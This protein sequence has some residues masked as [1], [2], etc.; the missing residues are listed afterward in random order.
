M[1]ACEMLRGFLISLQALGVMEGEAGNVDKA[2][3]FFE[4]STKEDPSHVHSWQV[5]LSRCVRHW[6][7]GERRQTCCHAQ[8]LC[9]LRQDAYDDLYVMCIYPAYCLVL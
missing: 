5:K 9:L 3:E 6:W 4:R 1:L 2:R 8:T 7:E